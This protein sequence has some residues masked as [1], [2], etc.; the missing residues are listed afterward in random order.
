[1]MEEQLLICFFSKKV[2][3]PMNFS[4]AGTDEEVYLLILSGPC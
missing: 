2:I 3:Q 4:P 1:M